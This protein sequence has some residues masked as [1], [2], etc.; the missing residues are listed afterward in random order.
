MAHNTDRHIDKNKLQL[1]KE[2]FLSRGTRP[3][4]REY[5]RPLLTVLGL[6]FKGFRRGG[7]WLLRGSG[8]AVLCLILLPA[9]ILSFNSSDSRP[10]QDSKQGLFLKVTSKTQFVLLL[11]VCSKLVQARSALIHFYWTCWEYVYGNCPSWMV[12]RK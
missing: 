8:W 5:S 6:P 7:V 4:E 12:I 1:K 2:L 10:P 3:R 11:H 9:H